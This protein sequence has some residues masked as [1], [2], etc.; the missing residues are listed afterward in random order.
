VSKKAQKKEAIAVALYTIA[1]YPRTPEEVVA[2]LFQ[3][4]SPEAPRPTPQ[5]KQVFASLDGK[6][7]A[8][9]RLARWAAKREG[10]QIRHRV[11]LTD[12][13]KALQA[14][15]RRQLPQ[16]TLV[17][18]IIHAVE[19]LWTAGTALYG[20]TDAQRTVWVQA[21]TLDLLAS[22]SDAVI[23]RLEDRAQALSAT[24]RAAKTLR[25]EAD[26]LRRN[27]PYMDYAR[28]LKL[29]WPIATGVVE[30]TCRHLV[31]DRMELSGMK[32]PSTSTLA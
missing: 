32:M 1:P 29:G 17:L 2:A 7:A 24:S 4:T 3:E 13:A 26:Y 8:L 10:W 27:R 9:R 16:F 23:V 25:R 11:A 6:A 28:Y 14:Q 18:D 15:M 21:Q 12:G 20:E 22:Q 5:H 30:G 31:K 19:H